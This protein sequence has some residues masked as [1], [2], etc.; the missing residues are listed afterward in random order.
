M[1]RIVAHSIAI[2][3]LALAASLNA[4]PIPVLDD[5]FEAAE[6][7]ADND[8]SGAWN[9]SNTTYGNPYNYVWSA[10][11]KGAVSKDTGYTIQSGDKFGLVFDLKDLDNID[12]ASPLVATLF[13]NDGVSDVVLGTASYLD[14]GY[15]T[16]WNEDVTLS[17]VN[18]TAGSVGKNLLVSFDYDY[19]GSSGQSRLGVDNVNIEAIPEA[20]AIVFDS[21]GNTSGTASGIA[22]SGKGIN[23]VV[24]AGPGYVL[25][26]V[27]LNI[28]TVGA[29]STFNVMIWSD[30]GTGAPIGTLLETLT[31]PAT[32]AADST[33]TFVS[34][35]GLTLTG[36]TTYWLVA[37]GAGTGGANIWYWKSS[38]DAAA[39]GTNSARLY[40][41]GSP[42]GWN[43]S[44]S[45]LNAA[46]INATPIP[47]KGTVIAIK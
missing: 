10:G 46:T 23:F 36:G 15:P 28:G 42:G 29:S 31:N 21:I 6:N 22:A 4:A 27:D 19:D 26:S 38:T 14:G 40:G 2:V 43:S 32:V 13:Y 3:A 20:T 11:D 8:W 12:T 24:P 44:S 33:N 47:P 1:K 9:F 39:T 25:R 5:G 17:N 16:A 41:G 45:Y 37:Q 18:A 30:D 34:F 35:S 7:L